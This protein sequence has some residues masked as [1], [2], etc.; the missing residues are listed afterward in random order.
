MVEGA[1]LDGRLDNAKVLSLCNLVEYGF[2]HLKADMCS[3]ELVTETRCN[4]MVSQ[5]TEGFI[6]LLPQKV[7][8]SFFTAETYPG[9]WD[10]LTTA[11]STSLETISYIVF[12]G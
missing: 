12:V 1:Y 7:I 2:Q 6:P 8:T 10:T 3:I 11:A 5:W 4:V 9:P